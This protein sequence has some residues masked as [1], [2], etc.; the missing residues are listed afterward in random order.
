MIFDTYIAEIIKINKNTNI[1]RSLLFILF[2]KKIRK[3]KYQENEK[4]YYENNHV[5]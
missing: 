2:K 3:I 1:L 5:Q 4:L